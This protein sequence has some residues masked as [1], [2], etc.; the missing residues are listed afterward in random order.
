MLGGRMLTTQMIRLISN[1]GIIIV[2]LGIILWGFLLSARSQRQSAGLADEAKRT[3][4][5][6]VSITMA[7]AAITLV[8]VLNLVL[9]LFR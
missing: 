9:D 2:G 3:R 5:R 7:G 6:V 4:G 1:S 8:G